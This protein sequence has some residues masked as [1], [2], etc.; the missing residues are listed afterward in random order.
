MNATSV[1]S[2]TINEASASRARRTDSSNTE[3]VAM[4]SSPR[5]LQRQHVIHL[6]GPN[7]QR[8]MLV[9]CDPGHSGLP[10]YHP[11]WGRSPPCVPP[12]LLF[13]QSRS[14]NLAAQRVFVGA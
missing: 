12:L 13:A 5:P 9:D 1:R 10:G 3:E 6:L 2:I 4:S 14:R 7:R 11:S 8:T